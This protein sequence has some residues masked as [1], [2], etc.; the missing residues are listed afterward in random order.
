MLR[1]S[2]VIF[3]LM[4]L[5][6]LVILIFGIARLRKKSRSTLAI[7]ALLLGIAG[8]GYG[9]YYFAITGG[10]YKC[11][12]VVASPCTNGIKGNG[13]KCS[14]EDQVCAQGSGENQDRRCKTV[15]GSHWWESDCECKCT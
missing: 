1:T 3:S 10:Y 11:K 13:Y 9:G 5:L 2:N 7:A 15:A 6:G 8:V 14:N 4:T 12:A